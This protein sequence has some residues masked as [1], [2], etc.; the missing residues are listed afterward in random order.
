VLGVG[1]VAVGSWIQRGSR[2]ADQT[3]AGGESTN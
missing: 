2:R 1:N 3:Q